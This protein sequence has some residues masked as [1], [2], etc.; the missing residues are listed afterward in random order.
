MVLSAFSL[1][2]AVAE[3]VTSMTVSPAFFTVSMPCSH[4]ALTSPSSSLTR[5]LLLPVMGVLLPL[6]TPLSISRKLFL[7]APAPA[8]TSSAASARER[9]VKEAKS[10]RRSED[11]EERDD[12]RMERRVRRAART[13]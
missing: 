2:V 7:A 6:W 9:R 5:S 13:D 12:Q 1:T 10:V 3:R 11:S 8:S 4:F